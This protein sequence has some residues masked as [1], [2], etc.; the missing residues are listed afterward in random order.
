MSIQYYF[1]CP[2][3]LFLK[4][5]AGLVELSLRLNW[6]LKVISCRHSLLGSQDVDEV[7]PP[8]TTYCFSSLMCCSVKA[9]DVSATHTL[10][11]VQNRQQPQRPVIFEKMAAL[12]SCSKAKRDSWCRAEEVLEGADK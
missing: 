12:P 6:V 7:Y 9:A 4:L 10:P 1:H 3:F 8:T 5:C 2:V 11:T